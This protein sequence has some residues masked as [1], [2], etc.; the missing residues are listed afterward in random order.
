MASSLWVLS[1]SH[2]TTPK[3]PSG[4]PYSCCSCWLLL[5]AELNVTGWLK[6]LKLMSLRQHGMMLCPCNTCHLWDDILLTKPN[7][8]NRIFEVCQYV[9][10]K[11]KGEKNRKSKNAQNPHVFIPGWSPPS[12]PATPQ[13]LPI[14]QPGTRSWSWVTWDKHCTCDLGST[15]REGVYTYILGFSDFTYII[16]IKVQKKWTKMILPL[17][18]TSPSSHPIRHPSHR[19]LQLHCRPSHW[20]RWRHRRRNASPIVQQKI[21]LTLGLSKIDMEKPWGTQGK[22]SIVGFPM[23]SRSQLTGRSV[24]MNCW[25]VL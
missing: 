14:A 10:K 16:H 24:A 22:W 6:W 2:G 5:S 13:P 3:R 12:R 23:F 25:D 18:L 1:R 19:C 15:R 8:T 7:A 20:A 11:Q 9:K 4:N 17:Q 21:L